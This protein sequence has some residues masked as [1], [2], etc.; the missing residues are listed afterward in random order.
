MLITKETMISEALRL[1]ESLAEVFYEFGMHCLGCPIAHGEN[2]G[3]AAE[4]HG[5]DADA[6]LEA[7]NKKIEK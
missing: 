4:A 1:D 5:I 7:L 6:L 3:Q 2:I